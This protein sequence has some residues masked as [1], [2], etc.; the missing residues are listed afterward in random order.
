[1]G[2]YH[3]FRIS[4]IPMSRVNEQIKRYESPDFSYDHDDA[5]RDGRITREFDTCKRKKVP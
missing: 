3:I 1:M 5:H 2:L 4:S